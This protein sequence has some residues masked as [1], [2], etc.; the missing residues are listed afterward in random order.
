MEKSQ[1][2]QEIREELK[3]LAE[4]FRNNVSKSY[5]Y[6][7]EVSKI[8]FDYKLVVLYEREYNVASDQATYSILYIFSLGE[9]PRRIYYQ[10]TYSAARS[11]PEN[12]IKKIVA[13]DAHEV[14]YINQLYETKTIRF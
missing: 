12:E 7:Y 3:K 1:E 8:F 14:H 2:I 9:E 10:K 4:V 11:L 5:D 13:V 6:W